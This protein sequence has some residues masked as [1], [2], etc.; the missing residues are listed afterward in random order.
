MYCAT[1]D[2]GVDPIDSILMLKIMI[3]TL[4]LEDGGWLLLN[5]SNFKKNR[6]TS[7]SLDK[8][9]S[10]NIIETKTKQY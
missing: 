8:Y 3:G 9:H 5:D 7:L 6:N 2:H 4:A 1:I 10:E